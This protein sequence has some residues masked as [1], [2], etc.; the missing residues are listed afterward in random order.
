MQTAINAA[1]DGATIVINEGQHLLNS[2]IRIN[3]PL[4][5]R[6]QAKTRTVLTHKAN[7]S[8]LGSSGMIHTGRDDRVAVRGMT[9][10]DMTLRADRVADPTMRTVGI[11]V[12]QNSSDVII[13]DIHFEGITSSPV[14]MIGQN[15]A[16]IQVINC[17]ANEYYEQFVEAG[18]Q[19][20]RGL[21]IANNVAK[22]TKGHPSL[23]TTEPFPV[24]LTPGYAGNGSG[25]IDG[26]WIIGNDFDHRGM[27]SAE[28][29]NTAG[30]QLS[31]DQ[32]AIGNQF[33]FKNVHIIG[34]KFRHQGRG[35]RLQLFRT[36][37]MPSEPHGFVVIENNDFDPIILGVEPFWIEGRA[38]VNDLILIGRNFVNFQTCGACQ[39]YKITTQATVLKYGNKCQ[40][41]GVSYDC[42]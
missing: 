5:L 21:L 33:G 17:S 38:T 1:Q 27:T 40:K 16:N 35:V 39:P 36:S 10:S 19:H 3:K 37:A 11:R 18:L 6:G 9:I 20:S 4:H 26:V 32:Q 29:I 8:Y 14:F 2:P 15:M 28:R 25:L 13:R 34:N 30:V 7:I 31:S 41:S 22:T 23:G 12:R 42:N 24:A